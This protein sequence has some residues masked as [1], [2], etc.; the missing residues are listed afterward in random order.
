LAGVAAEST[1]AL[2]ASIDRA[3]G[4]A[5]LLGLLVLIAVLGALVYGVVQLTG[6]RR[7]GRTRQGAP[8]KAESPE[9]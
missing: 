9:R 1:Y 5:P 8:E 4:H 2:L 6:K 7:A 3:G